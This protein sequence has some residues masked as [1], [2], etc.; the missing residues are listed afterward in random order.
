MNQTQ[1]VGRALDILFVLAESET[2]LTV[3]EIAEKVPLP[4]STAYRLIKTLE[5]NGVVER[6]SKGQISLGIRILDLARSLHQQIDRD[7]LTIAHP[8]MEALTEHLNETSILVVRRGTVGITVL[9]VECRRLIGFLVKKDKTH[10][11]HRGASGKAILAFED[12]RMIN[13]VLTSVD[14]EDHEGLYTELEKAREDGF[15]KTVAEVD[16]DTFAVAA[17]IF[18][19]YNRVIASIAIVGPKG[20]FDEPVI[21]TSIDEVLKASKTITEQ[22]CEHQLLLS[23]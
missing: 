14:E 23:N 11:L 19:E 17:P 15:I 16:P 10:P 7:L 3:G 13:K 18:D 5:L 2:T 6:K 9:H 1:T 21:E 4:E 12:E 22:I 8:I 20:R